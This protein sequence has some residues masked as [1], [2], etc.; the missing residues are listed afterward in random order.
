MN[1]NPSLNF[2]PQKNQPTKSGKEQSQIT[3]WTRRGSTKE[4]FEARIQKE[5]E[6]LE[7]GKQEE[8]KYQQLGAI[9]KSQR[10]YT[11]KKYS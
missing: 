6:G 9:T 7:R 2:V 10:K 11:L 1:P 5:L 3:C 4:Y 8:G